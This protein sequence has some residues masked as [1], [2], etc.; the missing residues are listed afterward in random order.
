MLHVKI[1]DFLLH[2][3]GD[4]TEEIQAN[5]TLLLSQHAATRAEQ[6]EVTAEISAYHSDTQ[7]KR[8]ILLAAKVDTQLDDHRQKELVRGALDMA[9]AIE[10]LAELQTSI[11]APPLMR[12]ASIAGSATA[13][14]AGQQ[15]QQLQQ[16]QQQQ[17]AHQAHIA[18]QQQAI[19]VMPVLV[20][21]IFNKVPLR[22]QTLTA[23]PRSSR[24]F[25][26]MQDT[27]DALKGSMLKQFLAQFEDLL[28]QSSNSGAPVP[29]EVEG[30][31]AE[32]QAWSQ[33]DSAG[34]S[35]A[36][37]RGGGGRSSSS[38]QLWEMFLTNARE[39]L[40]SYCLLSIL[41]IVLSESPQ[42][43]QE[44]YI[45]AI[46]EVLAPMW[47]RFRFHLRQST[48]V[49]DTAAG[50]ADAGMSIGKGS[51]QQVLWTFQYCR[52]FTKLLFD[53]CTQITMP[54][55]LRNVHGS[56]SAKGAH[57]TRETGTG[58][59]LLK[60]G[61]ACLNEI[62]QA[63]PHP[64]DAQSSSSLCF[65]DIFGLR[66]AS[67]KHIL[68]KIIHFFQAHLAE[69]VV[70]ATATA[71]SQHYN[72]ARARVDISTGTETGAPRV[73][74]SI[75]RSQELFVLQ[76]IEHTLSLDLDLSALLQSENTNE[77][78]GGRN[79]ISVGHVG[80][81]CIDVFCAAKNIFFLWLKGDAAH[82]QQLVAKV[83][84]IDSKAAAAENGSSSVAD[85]VGIFS[86][87]F[88][89]AFSHNRRVVDAL[90][91]G[92]TNHNAGDVPSGGEG[93]LFCYKAPYAIMR[94]F[95]TIA[96]RY[97]ALTRNS[98]IKVQVQFSSHILEPLLHLLVSLL[99]L[100]LRSSPALCDLSDGI[101]PAALRQHMLYSE[102]IDIIKLNKQA[103]AAT[104]KKRLNQ[105]A[106]GDGRTSGGSGGGGD[107]AVVAEAEST[108]AHSCIQSHTGVVTASLN[109]QQQEGQ[110]E[111]LNASEENLEV[112]SSVSGKD[113]NAQDVPTCHVLGRSTADGAL[114]PTDIADQDAQK[115]QA[116]L[117][118][119][120][121]AQDF[122]PLEKIKDTRSYVAQVLQEL[123]EFH[124]TVEYLECCLSSCADHIRNIQSAGA[125]CDDSNTLSF[126]TAAL[127]LGHSG[128][129]TSYENQWVKIHAWLPRKLVPTAPNGDLTGAVCAQQK[130]LVQELHQKIFPVCAMESEASTSHASSTTDTT[131]A[132]A[133]SNSRPTNTLPRPS[134]NTTATA[135]A[136]STGNSTTNTA[137]TA[138]GTGKGT[139]STAN[140]DSSLLG[141]SIDMCRAQMALLSQV[142]YIQETKALQKIKY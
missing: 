26:Y 71:T 13:E 17:E 73:N 108:G 40:S 83:L 3:N 54:Q 130:D 106:D 120:N 60:D 6:E 98:G 61:A 97:S 103:Q 39:W 30:G 136:S 135:A 82:V 1:R 7:T 101:L 70:A 58:S 140:G 92:T 9:A 41:P 15:Q 11:D 111:A 112:T 102:N 75:S 43:V 2:G 66:A 99:V 10:A 90:N 142:L 141:D 84:M 124:K 107:M 125:Q 72:T 53:L 80:N 93:G 105:A 113:I 134:S 119:E 91:T 32:G 117:A 45:R 64:H 21:Q 115:Q 74:A 8:S 67:K 122:G 121:N 63:L 14:E 31:I 44:A 59:A 69:V 132:A 126:T 129:G 35:S 118:T 65:T 68:S 138:I 4:S 85:S 78:A 131:T 49:I 47:G 12:L 110:L 95:M 123:Q 42:A 37:G 79:D 100:R 50:A 116:E 18:V 128:S 16:L 94:L 52:S 62:L 114:Q 28:L 38:I 22:S 89:G 96:Q 46:D 109:E 56:L 76:L 137:I 51:K 20:L 139:P 86:I 88:A 19:Q 127:G 34:S 24:L 29:G 133:A 57:V 77:G 104:D 25:K 36:A 87:L 33:E 27:V 23:L 55:K 81:S 5:A 48:G